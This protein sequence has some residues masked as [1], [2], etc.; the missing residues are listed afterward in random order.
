VTP[1]LDVITEDWAAEVDINN[2]TDIS[3]EDPE[4]RTT[5]I[6]VTAY[7]GT[8]QKTYTVLFRYAHK[9][10]TLS[11]LSIG[12]G[13]LEP[14]F[15][16]DS[17]AYTVCL[18]RLE[19]K[20]PEVT[21]ETTDPYG[22]FQIEYALDIQSPFKPWRTTIITVTSEDGRQTAKY[23]IEHSIDKYPVLPE[24]TLSEDTVILHGNIE[25]TSTESGYICL[26]PEDTDPHFDSVMADTIH[27]V[28]AV[29]DVAAY[30]PASDTGKY[31]LYAI[32]NCLNVSSSDMVTIIDTTNTGISEKMTANVYLYPN[33]VDRIL[34]IETAQ[35]ITSV[36][37][38][39]VIGVKVLD[40]SKPEGR[41]D[42]GQ[43]E[44]GMYLIRIRT[45]RDEVFTGKVMKK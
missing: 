25:I 45:D 21:C 44:Q 2:A 29:A 6:T 17:L 13:T 27:S 18:P 28:K 16:T 35:I 32:D 10:S 1:Q 7:D 15:H 11:F 34:Y 5:T 36:E 19:I 40:T 20:T 24:I 33:P 31:W 38:F 3:S 23:E 9:D 42:M 22:S 12:K 4:D 43:L 14:E 8:T 41:I 26:V 30:L 39:N 37:L